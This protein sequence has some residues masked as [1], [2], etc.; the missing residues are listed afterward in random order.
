MPHDSI[1]RAIDRTEEKL[2]RLRRQVRLHEEQETPETRHAQGPKVR[3]ALAAVNA[4][5]EVVAGHVHRLLGDT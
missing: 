1:Y 5:L 2:E 4:P 3:Q